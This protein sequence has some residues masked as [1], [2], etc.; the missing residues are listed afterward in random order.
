MR[1]KINRIKKSQ[2]QSHPCPALLDQAGCPRDRKNLAAPFR[3]EILNS[4]EPRIA[5]H[6]AR[7]AR[8]LRSLSCRCRRMQIFT[9]S[10]TRRKKTGSRYQYI[11]RKKSC[12]TGHLVTLCALNNVSQRLQGNSGEPFFACCLCADDD[13]VVLDRPRLAS[14]VENFPSKQARTLSRRS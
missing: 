10:N 13:D 2:S 14:L 7:L 1:Y 8:D 11:V 9:L 5:S 6:S 4:N 12:R 3:T